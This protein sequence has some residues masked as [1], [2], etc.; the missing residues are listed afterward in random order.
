M[1]SRCGGSLRIYILNHFYIHPA[2]E[3]VGHGW[4]YAH[5]TPR[6]LPFHR[7]MLK[8]FE[9]E[10][11][12]LGCPY[13]PY[14]DWVTINKKKSIFFNFLTHFSFSRWNLNIHGSQLFFHPNTLENTDLQ[15]GLSL[16]RYVKVCIRVRLRTSHYVVDT[17]RTMVQPFIIQA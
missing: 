17:K 12:K 4:N 8:L 9:Q 16:V 10:L 1:K 15:E 6:F 11:Q 3:H 13:I 5:S 2:W 14:W 7:V